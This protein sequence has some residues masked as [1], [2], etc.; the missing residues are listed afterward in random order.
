MMEAK[1]GQQNEYEQVREDLR[2]LQEDMAKLTRSVAEGQKNNISHLR[3]EIR[4]ESREAFDQVK[5]RGDEALDRAKDVSG[6]AVENVEHKI[7]ERPFLS[8][9][10]M[11]LAGL[12]VGRL[13][14]R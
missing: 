11:F 3:D 4:R 12:L 13:L 8:I 14:D 5:R 10:L 6:K 2:R 1:S 9:V 7:E